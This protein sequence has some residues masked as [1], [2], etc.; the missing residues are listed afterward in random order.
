MHTSMPAYR[1][2]VFSEVNFNWIL[3]YWKVKNIQWIEIIYRVIPVISMHWM[4]LILKHIDIYYTEVDYTENRSLCIEQLK[5]MSCFIRSWYCP[6]MGIRRY[7]CLTQN[8]LLG[9]MGIA[10]RLLL[11]ICLAMAKSR[12]AS[13]ISSLQDIS[14]KINL[15]LLLIL[16]SGLYEELSLVKS[17]WELN[18]CHV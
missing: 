17:M 16:I 13:S 1:N 4:N 14:M 18:N 2:I 5:C 7:Q 15:C 10:S 3:I 6:I 12:C 8:F 11:Y 9:L